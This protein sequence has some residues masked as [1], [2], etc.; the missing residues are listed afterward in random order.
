MLRETLPFADRVTNRFAVLSQWTIVLVLSGALMLVH[1]S[2][3]EVKILGCTS[4]S[5]GSEQ[6][7]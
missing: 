6:A 7:P 4:S 1:D 5:V 2:F 3:E